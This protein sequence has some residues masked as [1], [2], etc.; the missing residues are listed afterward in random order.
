MDLQT[1]DDYISDV[2]IK[3]E[4]RWSYK[5]AIIGFLRNRWVNKL[6]NKLFN[7]YDNPKSL[8]LKLV[9]GFDYG[10]FSVA[11]EEYCKK[12]MEYYLIDDVISEMLELKKKNYQIIIV[13]GGY[14]IYIKHFFSSVVDKVIATE[15]DFSDSK[16]L[17]K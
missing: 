14:D 5:L 9:K 17:G 2:I 12:L 10:V 3:K 1:A 7:N 8:I 6:F 13:S 15:I 16:C 4:G 11:A